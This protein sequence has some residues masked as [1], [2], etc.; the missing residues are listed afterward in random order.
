LTNAQIANL[1]A[2]GVLVLEASDT[3]V[4]L[5]ATLAPSLQGAQMRVTAPPGDIVQISDTAAH[6]EGLPAGQI[7]GLTVVGVAG[8]VSTN[9]NVSYSPTQTAAILSSGLNVSVSGAYT[10]TENFANG[11]YS[12]YQGGQLIQQDPSSTL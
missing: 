10:V 1:S 9:A 5:S 12:V 7:T 8:L 6:L 2:R 3:S 4:A 11:D